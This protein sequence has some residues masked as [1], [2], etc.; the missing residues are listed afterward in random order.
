MIGVFPLT[1]NFDF[2]FLNL[3][4]ENFFGCACNRTQVTKTLVT[5]RTKGWTFLHLQCIEN[6]LVLAVFRN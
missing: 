5:Q 1:K 3:V 2:I 6:D 4:S